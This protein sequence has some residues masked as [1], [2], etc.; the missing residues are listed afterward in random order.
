MDEDGMGWGWRDVDRPI[1]WCL[2]KKEAMSIQL[3]QMAGGVFRDRQACIP[4]GVS[5]GALA[6]ALDLGDL[7]DGCVGGGRSRV[8]E[9]T[10]LTFQ[11]DDVDLDVDGLISCH[12]D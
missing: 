9:R 8:N 10:C 11:R 12:C 3:D 5:A 6:V 2:W 1:G 7:C 4:A